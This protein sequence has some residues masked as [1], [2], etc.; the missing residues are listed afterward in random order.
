MT[1]TNREL[2]FQPPV[3]LGNK[4]GYAMTDQVK[5]ISVDRLV[6]RHHE[7]LSTEEIE[8]VRFA[9]RRIIDVGTS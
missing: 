7:T 8:T 9:L 5:S 6:S 4:T 3:T 1:T 2:P